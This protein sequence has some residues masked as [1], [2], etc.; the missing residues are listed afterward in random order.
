MGSMIRMD[1]DEP[2]DGGYST[3]RVPEGWR[4]I[5]AYTNDREVIICGTPPDLEHD[6]PE[7]A[8]HNCDEMGCGTLDHVIARFV[9]PAPYG[10]VG[11]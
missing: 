6:V 8:W 3:Q 10:E 11:T 4:P 5:V 1:A 7:D 9:L 2:R